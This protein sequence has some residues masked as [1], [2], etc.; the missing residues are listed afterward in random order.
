[1]LLCL[2]QGPSEGGRIMTGIAVLLGTFFDFVLCHDRN[3]NHGP[4]DRQRGDEIVLGR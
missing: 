3:G 2:R 1:M 4:V